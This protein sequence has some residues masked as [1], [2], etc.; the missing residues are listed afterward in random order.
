VGQYHGEL[1]VLWYGRPIN[2]DSPDG[3]KA[4]KEAQKKKEEANAKRHAALDAANKRTQSGTIKL[5]SACESHDNGVGKAAVAEQA[6]KPPAVLSPRKDNRL[7]TAASVPTTTA[8]DASSTQEAQ[9]TVTKDCEAG[10]D[11]GGLSV[12]ALAPATVT[13][14]LTKVSS[15]HAHIAQSNDSQKPPSSSEASVQ[16]AID[17][18]KDEH[19]SLAW[20]LNTSLITAVNATDLDQ[21]LRALQQGANPNTPDSSG[22]RCLHRG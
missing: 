13:A 8:Q 18:A 2:P 5:P 9:I 22:D 17:V 11:G 19:V 10:V 14:S 16:L 12:L 4:A 21:C 15:A 3:I 7:S 1:K 6:E 20:K